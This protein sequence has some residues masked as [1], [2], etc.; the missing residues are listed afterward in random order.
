MA[1]YGTMDDPHRFLRCFLGVLTCRRDLLPYHS[2]IAELCSQGAPTIDLQ[3][4]KR[5]QLS[6][7]PIPCTVQV[8]SSRFVPSE[9][10]CQRIAGPGPKSKNYINK[11]VIT[12]KVECSVWNALSEHRVSDSRLTTLIMWMDANMVHLP[13]PIGWAQPQKVAEM[14][15]G[16]T[17]RALMAA[18]CRWGIIHIL[19]IYISI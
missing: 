18:G 10:D 15:T 8:W 5:L 1:L 4:P 12:C 6:A 2:G 11:T 13:A 16:R 3:K 19:Y 7:R 14:A 17:Q 9:F